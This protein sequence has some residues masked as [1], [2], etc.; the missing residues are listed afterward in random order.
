MFGCCGWLMAFAIRLTSLLSAG[1][2]TQSLSMVC[3]LLCCVGE[4]TVWYLVV[5]GSVRIGCVPS[6]AW[7]AAVFHGE[8]VDISALSVGVVGVAVSGLRIASRCAR[9]CGAGVAARECD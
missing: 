6:L 5:S 4:K 1:V 7:L 8:S 2:F 9:D 3:C